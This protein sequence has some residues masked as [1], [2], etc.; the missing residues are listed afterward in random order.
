MGLEHRTSLVPVVA[1]VPVALK[2]AR[3]HHVTGSGE[4]IGDD[5]PIVKRT[6]GSI[7]VDATGESYRGADEVSE[8][9]GVEE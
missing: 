6:I 1:R 9:R 3:P 8:D 2:L 4:A 7:T 5:T